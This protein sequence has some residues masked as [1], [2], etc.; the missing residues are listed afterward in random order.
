MPECAALGDH[1]RGQRRRFGADDLDEQPA[2]AARQLR[3][4]AAPRPDQVDDPRVQPLAGDHR[5]VGGREQRRHGVGRLDH[6]RV[7]EHDQEPLGLVLD[8]PHGRLADQRERALRADQ[9]PVD[10]A[11][12][13]G[14]QVLE[15]VAAHLAAEPAE[16]GAH[17]REVL[18]DQGARAAPRRRCAPGPPGDVQRDHVVDRP[19]VAERPRAAGVV[20][21]HPA[22]RAAGVRRRVRPEAQAVRRR[23]ALQVGVHDAGLDDRGTRLGVDRDDPVEVLDRVDDDAGADG[24]AG[25]RG[26]GAAHGDRYAGGLRDVE[27]RVQLV[28]GARPDD[29]LRDHAV[30]RGVGGVERPGQG[31]VVDV[32]DAPAPQLRNEICG[33]GGHLTSVPSRRRTPAPGPPPWAPW[34]RS[35]AAAAAG[36]RRRRGRRRRRRRSRPR[37]GRWG[38]RCRASAR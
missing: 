31:R 6:R 2:G 38:S 9:E 15:R 29:H 20:A 34:V 26:A 23:R 13:L 16:L 4:R 33:A 36:S 24:V 35:R 25:D 17:V 11:A 10:A 12:V 1:R 30:E 8:Q 22:D 19:A 37:P 14:Q 3:H 5:A 32:G 18:V 28:G 21:D 7:A 27:D